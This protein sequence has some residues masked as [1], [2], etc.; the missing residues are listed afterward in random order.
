MFVGFIWIN[1]LISYLL[2]GIAESLL[3]AFMLSVAGTSYN[4]DQAMSIH[5]L[6]KM[7]LN[8]YQMFG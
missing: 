5:C 7:F 2:I 4:V 6:S 8:V 3:V 1:I